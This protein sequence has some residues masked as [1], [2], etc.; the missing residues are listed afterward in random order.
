MES[1]V[2]LRFQVPHINTYHLHT[3][4]IG[5]IVALIYIDVCALSVTGN[6]AHSLAIDAALF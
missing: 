6:K 4:H 2:N 1:S 3:I 5:D